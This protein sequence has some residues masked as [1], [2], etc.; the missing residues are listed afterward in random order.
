M[1]IISVELDH[2][3]LNLLMNIKNFELNFLVLFTASLGLK[4]HYAQS[5]DV[6]WKLQ[7]TSSGHMATR[8]LRVGE[9]IMCCKDFKRLVQLSGYRVESSVLVIIF[10]RQYWLPQFTVCPVSKWDCF[11]TTFHSRNF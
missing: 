3:F 4:V 2:K 9:M 10:F 6:L 8:S 7:H 5:A 11:L 1:E